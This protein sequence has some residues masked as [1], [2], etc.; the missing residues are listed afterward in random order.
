MIISEAISLL[1]STPGSL[2][3]HLT[4]ATDLALLFGLAHMF[5]VQSES[6]LYNRWRLAAG[7]LFGAR[8][9]LMTVAGATWLL[10]VEGNLFLPPMDRFVSVTG[11]VVLFWAILSTKSH[12]PS[13]MS[14]L[15]ALGL[16]LVG[17]IVNFVVLNGNNLDKPFNSTLADAA[18]SLA[19]LSIA[20]SAAII[21]TLRRPPKWY[22]NLGGFCL[23]TAGFVLHMTQGSKDSSLAGFV[24]WAELGAYPL[25]TMAATST[26]T[27][28]QTVSPAIAQEATLERSPALGPSRF[29]ILAEIASIINA[30]KTSEL[31][32]LIVKSLATSMRA[33]LCLLLTAPDPSG[34]FAIATV[35]DLIHER[36][37][38][39]ATLDSKNCP[40]IITALNRHR[41]LRL[42]AASRSPDVQ[43]LQAKLNVKSIGPSLLVPLIAEEEVLGG[44]M[45]LSP[46]TRRPWRAEDQIAMEQVA[47]HIALRL[48]QLNRTAMV[49]TGQIIA[50]DKAL[51]ETERQIYSLEQTITHLT[52]QLQVNSD[53]EGLSQDENLSTLLETHNQAL[54]TIQVLEAETERLKATVHE[55]ML[56][57]SPD[58]IKR[59]PDNYQMAIRELHELRAR[60]AAAETGMDSAGRRTPGSLPDIE[61]ITSIAK[62]LH[63]SMSSITEYTDLLLGETVGT[64]GTTQRN[65]IEQVRSSIEKM[66]NLVE[67][68]LQITAVET[69]KLSLTPE[70]VDL[71]HCIDEAVSQAS[72]MLG[73]KKLTLRMDF[74]DQ[75]HPI[76]G[77]QGLIVQIITHLFNNAIGAS[78]EG[79][80]IIIAARI[81]E[82]EGAEFIMLTISDAGE[83]IP[84][85]DLGR[86]FQ[87]VEPADYIPIPGL[88]ES[89][90]SLSIVQDLSEAIGGR[91]WF[92]SEVGIGSTFTIL[93]PVNDSSRHEINNKTEG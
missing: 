75:I 57:M 64:L 76:V 66:E 29:E 41:S 12:H 63:Q 34:Q 33:E 30:E 88:G 25:L 86:V 51:L 67:N 36:H 61:V 81:Q 74:P 83:G 77:E 70:P 59:K 19:G 11:I 45:L 35:Y 79:E 15:I 24:R 90:M 72:A 62:E 10:L 42:P 56:N 65:F 1:T 26:L 73:K 92:D 40:V 32:I 68:L 55:G 7:G 54:E 3:Y 46:Y 20:L 9:I 47:S 8:L 60:L 5:Y 80:E 13:N 17:M 71:L 37:L 4:L 23:L 14:L 58:E 53:T 43:T 84:T 69:S 27:F 82:A 38:P 85:E 91:I 31:A 52:A 89:S 93:M 18:W 49:A 22:L 44:V 50:R 78:P 6:P 48:L 2:V 28:S 39:G 16:G 21:M 87:R